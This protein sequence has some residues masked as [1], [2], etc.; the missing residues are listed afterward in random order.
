MS[1]STG[2]QPT[3]W[4]QA[5]LNMRTQ[6]NK[7]L[8]SMVAP[9]SEL[10]YIHPQGERVYES[11]PMRRARERASGGLIDRPETFDDVMQNFRH[12]VQQVN[13]L[14]PDLHMPTDINDMVYGRQAPPPQPHGPLTEMVYGPNP[15]IGE[16]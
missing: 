16:Q 2:Y 1:N 9:P 11:V 5:A 6:G 12:R 8:P 7:L 13:A 4:D 14:L 15:L 3:I 10:Q